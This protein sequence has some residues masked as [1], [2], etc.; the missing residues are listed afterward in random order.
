MLSGG[1][2][3]EE[4]RFAVCPETLVSLAINTFMAPNEAIVIRGAEQFAAYSGYGRSLSFDGD[5]KDDTPLD[6]ERQCVDVCI[7]CIDAN[8]YRR[9]GRDGQFQAEHYER[10]LIKL[11]AGLAHCGASTWSTG[12]WGCGVFLGHAPHKFL[13]QHIVASMH[14]MSVS[15]FPFG[16]KDT[17]RDIALIVKALQGATVRDAFA[18]VR[19]FGELSAEER[20]SFAD[21]VM[22]GAEKVRLR[23]EP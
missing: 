6:A 20:P 18:L 21:F 23:S 16:E 14:G 3:Q 13:L 2:V 11:E 1:C 17:A 19:S 4:I 12:N 22:Q 8:D 9:G 15:Y 7:V 10:E 5:H